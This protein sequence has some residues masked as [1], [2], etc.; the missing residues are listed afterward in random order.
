MLSVEGSGSLGSRFVS[1][2]GFVHLPGVSSFSVSLLPT[3]SVSASVPSVASSLFSPSFWGPSRSFGRPAAHSPLPSGSCSCSCCLWR[4]LSLPSLLLLSLWLLLFVFCLFLLA[5]VLGSLWWPLRSPLHLIPFLLFYPLLSLRLLLLLHPSCSLLSVASF[6]STPIPSSAFPIVC[7]G[8]LAIVFSWSLPSVVSC[9]TPSV[10]S[11]LVPVHSLVPPVVSLG[12]SVSFSSSFLPPVTFHSL[13]PAPT[14][15]FAPS[16]V[17]GDPRSSPGIL[18]GPGFSSVLG[19]CVRLPHVSHL[20]LILATQVPL[21]LSLILFAFVM[22]M[23][24][25]IGWTRS[26]LHWIRPILS[27]SLS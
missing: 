15:L 13:H 14:S 21:A 24:L 26:L 2:S 10:A 25:R 16:G 5:L 4:F 3:S 27:K 19:G 12:P 20:M 23:T 18:A 11:V 8:S 9:S 22:V 17:P 7:S 1:S 6:L